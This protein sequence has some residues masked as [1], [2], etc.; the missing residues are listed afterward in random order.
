MCRKKTFFRDNGHGTVVRRKS[1]N[2]PEAPVAYPAPGDP[3]L[4]RRAQAEAAPIRQV[5]QADAGN[6]QDPFAIEDSPVVRVTAVGARPAAQA[7]ETGPSADD[8]SSPQKN[9]NFAF[10]DV[11]RPFVLSQESLE[12]TGVRQ[13][14]A[15][16]VVREALGAAAAAAVPV[17]A[18]VKPAAHHRRKKKKPIVRIDPNA[19]FPE[20]IAPSANGEKT[21]EERRAQLRPDTP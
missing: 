2:E 9:L 17:V 16:S 10:D 6:F 20:P 19:V 11:P 21:R 15:P 3:R 1:Q 13:H 8:A 4:H 12:S 14:V 5:P 18:T 7:A